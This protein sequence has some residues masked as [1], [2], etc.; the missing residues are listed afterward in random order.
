MDIEKIKKYTTLILEVASIFLGLSFII[1][2]LIWN[3]Y[4]SRLGFGEY[5]IIQTKFVSTGGLFL[6][7]VLIIL[8]IGVVISL[9][10]KKTEAFGLEYLRR[11]VWIKGAEL[12]IREYFKII[13]INKTILSL[14]N[15]ILFMIIPCI[16][17]I[18]FYSLYFFPKIPTTYGGGQP[19][20]LSILSNEDYIG[21]LSSFGIPAGEGSK[22]QTA[23]L[24][25]AYEN[26]NMIIII[27]KDRVLE[28]KKEDFKGFGSLF[29]ADKAKADFQKQCGEFAQALV[30]SF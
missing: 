29:G 23:N 4:L 6:F 13:P 22:I 8:L 18:I 12:K 3:I 25:V 26:E 30:K 20:S 16:F 15:I 27:L 1:G 9:F 7:L 14:L 11:F 5:N 2:F 24:C 17:L 21:Y 19:R 28:L 10:F